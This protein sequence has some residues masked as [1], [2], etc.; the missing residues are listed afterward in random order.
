MLTP[1]LYDPTPAIKAVASLL[2]ARAHVS[3]RFDGADSELGRAMWK[4][5]DELQ[6]EESRIA[7]MLVKIDNER[8]QRDFS[9][10]CASC[11]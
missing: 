2:S 7:V 5:L 11:W 3:R 1:T 6:G 4:V 10:M 9:A 8:T